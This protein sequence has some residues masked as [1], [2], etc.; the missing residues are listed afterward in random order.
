M[1]TL[2]TTTIGFNPIWRAFWSTKRVC[3]IGPSKASTRSMQPSAMLRTRSTSPPKSEWPGVS[4][5]F[6]F[7]PFQLMETF[8]ESIVM[9][10]SLSSS[11][12]SNTKSELFWPSRKR[13]PASI[14][15]STSV[16]LPWSTCA[17]MAM[18]LI[19]CILLVVLSGMSRASL[20]QFCVQRY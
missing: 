7:V 19:S 8:F 5:M 20:F 18:F 13:C 1:S 14:I 17:M 10:R 3:G 16:V 9:P 15:L 12:L 2:L 11:L 4:M 6:I